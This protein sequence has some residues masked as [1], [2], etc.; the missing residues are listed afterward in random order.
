VDAL[1]SEELLERHLVLVVWRGDEREDDFIPL[2]SSD[3]GHVHAEADSARFGT[4]VHDKV[5]GIRGPGLAELRVAG[6][7]KHK[8]RIIDT[9]T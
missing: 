1:E 2:A 9:V 7:G 3:V 8:I 4:G 5:R 6:F